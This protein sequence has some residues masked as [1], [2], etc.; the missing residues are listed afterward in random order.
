MGA[1]ASMDQRKIGV[2]D[3]FDTYTAGNVEW[4]VGIKDDDS[5][6]GKCMVQ[7]IS[8]QRIEGLSFREAVNCV[9]G[10]FDLEPLSADFLLEGEEEA[11]EPVPA[12]RPAE[13]EGTLSNG[14]PVTAWMNRKKEPEIE[15]EEEVVK[16]PDIQSWAIGDPSWIGALTPFS[17]NSLETMKVQWELTPKARVPVFLGDRIYLTKA[18]AALA[19]G[20]H[21]NSVNRSLN[22]GKT[23]CCGM[24]IGY[25]DPA[26]DAIRRGLTREQF[27]A[28]VR[29]RDGDP[30][31]PPAVDPVRKPSIEETAKKAL[32]AAAKGECSKLVPKPAAKAAAKAA[33]AEIEIAE[34]E[35]AALKE[36]AVA[37][38]V[39]NA[40][41][42]LELTGTFEVDVANE[43]VAL[44][45][46]IVDTKPKV[47][48]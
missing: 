1:D 36:E 11:D 40:K 4:V 7:P 14:L 23:E 30:V 48:F 37:V 32:E 24:A 9:L 19:E 35:V 13:S 16:N 26:L 15:E 5:I 6:A 12:P 2:R 25:A 38:I 43:I 31:P 29:E 45:R 47:S 3:K 20:V 46:R 10:E 18:L 22:E 27:A 39:R 41:G 8:G 42:E 34:R 28:E 44:C 17:K 21:V 33:D